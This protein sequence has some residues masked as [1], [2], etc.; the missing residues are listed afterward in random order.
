MMKSMARM[1]WIMM[2]MMIRM[3]SHVA[4]DAL[5]NGDGGDHGDDD[6]VFCLTSN[7]FDHSSVGTASKN[8]AGAQHRIVFHLLS[9][10]LQLW[11]GICLHESD[12]R[13]LI[14]NLIY[15]RIL[16][17]FCVWLGWVGLPEKGK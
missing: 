4:L 5:S 3:V 13:S 16:G 12:L 8:A 1:M 7:E 10:D 6:V 14:F 15:E 2:T 17:T 9:L 11:S